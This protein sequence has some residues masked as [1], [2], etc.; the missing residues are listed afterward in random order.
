MT[1]RLVFWRYAA[2]RITWLRLSCWVA[3]F[4]TFSWLVLLYLPSFILR[5]D[6]QVLGICLV[7]AAYNKHIPEFN[8]ATVDALS[9]VMIITAT[10]LILPTALDR[11]V[12]GPDMGLTF[13]R[14]SAVVLLVLYG[15]FLYFQLGTHAHLF[16][17]APEGGG[18]TS[19][20]RNVAE[21]QQEPTLSLHAASFVLIIATLGIIGCT[22]L[23]LESID[24]TA[25]ILNITEIFIGAILIPIAS[26]APECVTIMVA[27]QKG[28]I[29]YAIGVIVSSILQIALFVT[30]FLVILGW[31][32]GQPMTL[33]FEMFQTTMLF[34]AVLVVNRLLQDGKYTYIQG[35]MLIAL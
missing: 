16:V 2:V 9:S 32:I 10:A 6:I 29:N 7:S 28:K 18:I 23:L 24:E 17:D 15:M 21:E 30:P 20:E 11:T 8:M 5:Q 33:K 34:F 19:E 14:G 35:A 1:R 3:F 13:S 26:N 4:R 31:I 27:S 25:E 22:D 12:T